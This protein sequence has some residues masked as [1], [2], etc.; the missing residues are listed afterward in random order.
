MHIYWRSFVWMCLVYL[1]DATG[2]VYN[3]VVARS[4]DLPGTIELI[5]PHIRVADLRWRF[6]DDSGTLLCQNVCDV[7]V[8]C[9]IE[10]N[11]Y[12][13]HGRHPARRTSRCGRISGL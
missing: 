6:R 5:K 11:K 4:I 10:K 7:G 1:T 12:D 8:Y 3:R 9:K 13:D 2:L